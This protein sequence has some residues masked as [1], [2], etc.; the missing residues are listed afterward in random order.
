GIDRRLGQQ[1]APQV[2]MED[3][4]GGVNHTNMTGHTLGT[5]EI[6]QTDENSFFFY[7][8]CMTFPV[9]KFG[10]QCI[11]NLTALPGHVFT[12]IGV[13]QSLTVDMVE[14]TVDGWDFAQ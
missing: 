5:D 6:L 14:N 3:C 4:P 9:P 2:G 12:V 8:M 7:F 11:D 10:A 13:K 1:G